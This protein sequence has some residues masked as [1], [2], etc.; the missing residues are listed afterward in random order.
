[1]G[2]ASLKTAITENAAHFDHPVWVIGRPRNLLKIRVEQDVLFLRAR[3]AIPTD[4][5]EQSIISILTLI[6]DLLL[7]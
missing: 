4:Q 6:L 3:L 2:G 1:M 7:G 5:D